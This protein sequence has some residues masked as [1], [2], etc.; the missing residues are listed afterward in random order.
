MGF[1]SMMSGR[2]HSESQ[3]QK[4]VFPMRVKWDFID[5]I[6]HAFQAAECSCVNDGHHSQ[7][8]HLHGIKSYD[9]FD[10]FS[11]GS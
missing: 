4:P 3:P 10:S 1:F 8:M 5:P 2:A 7:V 11:L 9:T 6:I